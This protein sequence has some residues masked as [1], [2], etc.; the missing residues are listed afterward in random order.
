MDSKKYNIFIFIQLNFQNLCK[1]KYVRDLKRNIL[2]MY[3]GKIEE[4]IRTLWHFTHYR[5]YAI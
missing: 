3:I 5:I 2:G 1:R 4:K